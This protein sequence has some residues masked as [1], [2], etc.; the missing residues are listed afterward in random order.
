M[1]TKNEERKMRRLRTRPWSRSSEQELIL[2]LLLHISPP[3]HL[4]TWTPGQFLHC[5]RLALGSMSEGHG[6]SVR[7]LACTQ[8]VCVA[9]CL[10]QSVRQ[11]D[12]ATVR[13]CD[14]ATVTSPAP[15]TS[16]TSPR[17]PDSGRASK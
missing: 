5:S 1:G 12:S 15:P 10:R 3:P 9:V 2:L 8:L 7:E 11:C 6:S 4:S 13:Q 17:G 16:L 14:S